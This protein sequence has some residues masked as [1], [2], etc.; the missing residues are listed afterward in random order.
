MAECGKIDWACHANDAVAVINDVHTMDL[1]VREALAFY[2]KH[3]DETLIVITGDH[4][5]GGMTLGFAGTH[6]DAFLKKLQ[7]QKGSFD[8]FNEVIAAQKKAD[9]NITL[10]GFMPAISDFFGLHRY[11][12][13][14]Y[15]ALEAQA[16]QGDAAAE[17]ASAAFEKLGMALKDYEYADIE[18][19]FAETFGGNSAAASSTDE[20]YLLYGGYEPLTVTLTHIMGEKAGISFTTYSHTGLPTPVFAIGAGAAQFDGW[21]DNTDIYKKMAAIGGV[22]K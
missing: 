2:Q 6:Y 21:Y 16:K 10:E 11:T 20:G 18:K 7:H 4:E 19:A 5:T 14:E 1:A 17:A 9:A 12:A 13:D 8:A 22:S 3:P 15:A